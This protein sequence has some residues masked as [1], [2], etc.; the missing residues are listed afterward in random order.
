MSFF[1]IRQH[2][3]QTFVGMLS[4]NLYWIEQQMSQYF[5]T[6]LEHSHCVTKGFWAKIGSTWHCFCRS[7]CQA[8]EQ[9]REPWK[10]SP[11]TLSATACTLQKPGLRLLLWC[12][13]FYLQTWEAS[14]NVYRM[15]QKNVLLKFLESKSIYM[16]NQDTMYGY[17]HMDSFSLSWA[18]KRPQWAD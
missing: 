2:W 6:K 11:V 14:C 8:S 17:H 10:V 18:P 4:L 12:F 7:W 13:N 3:D 16:I 15:S 9:P 5:Q 1:K